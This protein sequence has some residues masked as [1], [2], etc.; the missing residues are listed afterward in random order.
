MKNTLYT[1]FAFTLLL[2]CSKSAT[3]QHPELASAERIMEHRPDS[4]LLFH[5]KGLDLSAQNGDTLAAALLNDIANVYAS[6]SGIGT[7]YFMQN[8]LDSASYYLTQAVCSDYIYTKAGSYRELYTLESEK[9]TQYKTSSF[10]LLGMSCLLILSYYM[11]QRRLKEKE[12]VLLK[13]MT[14]IETLRKRLSEHEEGNDKSELLHAERTALKGQDQHEAENSKAV[15]LKK[16]KT[17]MSIN[18]DLS[19]NEKLLIDCLIEQN[20]LLK[21]VRQC[22]TKRIA[23]KTKSWT[24]VTVSIDRLFGGLL[25][26]LQRQYPKLVDEDIHIC[27]LLLLNIKLVEIAYLISE[28]EDCINKRSERIRKK[29]SIKK[30]LNIVHFLMYKWREMSVQSACNTFNFEI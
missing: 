7:A 29:L 5:Q 2:A 6:Y 26:R 24:E 23:Y 4:A 19:E 17:L 12:H 3:T 11:C 28:E 14:Q 25:T 20:P 13:M 30:P 8:K 1:L 18:K 9:V 15:F 16:I 27:A 22:A 21:Q 10:I